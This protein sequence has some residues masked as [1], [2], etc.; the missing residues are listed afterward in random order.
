MKI[1]DEERI[2]DPKTGEYKLLIEID[3]DDSV[4]LDE[5]IRLMIDNGQFDKDDDKLLAKLNHLKEM[6][7]KAWV[8]LHPS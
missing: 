7:H 2:L 1:I 4:R 8:I 3:E 5:A 6:T